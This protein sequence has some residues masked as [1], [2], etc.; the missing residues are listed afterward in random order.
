LG[1]V[2]FRFVSFR[3]VPSIHSFSPYLFESSLLSGI[4]VVCISFAPK[5]FPPPLQD[6][7]GEGLWRFRSGHVRTHHPFG[8]S[9]EASDINILVRLAYASFMSTGSDPLGF[10]I[11]PSW[12]TTGSR[13]RYRKS[14][15]PKASRI[16]KN[17][18]LNHVRLRSGRSMLG[19]APV[20]GSSSGKISSLLDKQSNIN[21]LLLLTLV[22]R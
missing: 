3:S 6:C 7:V 16:W 11:H 12:I 9:P 20:V 17:A 5:F 19:P 22:G 10:L 4:V 8:N 14:R 15:G 18:K 13:Y 21:H 1:L 2:S